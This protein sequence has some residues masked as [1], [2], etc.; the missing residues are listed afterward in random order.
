LPQNYLSGLHSVV[1]TDSAAIGKGKTRRVSGKKYLRRDCLGFYNSARKGEA[2]SVELV[3]DNIIAQGFRG[4]A[5]VLTPFPFF[6]E[7]AFARILFHEVG[8][9]LD[10]TIGAPARTGEA[11][12]EK[13][14]E[15]LLLNYLRTRWSPKARSLAARLMDRLGLAPKTAAARP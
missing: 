9:H 11:A 7:T 2:A 14:C 10:H 4:R 15:L 3:V 8:H 5:A 12:A 6:R 1:L 13:W